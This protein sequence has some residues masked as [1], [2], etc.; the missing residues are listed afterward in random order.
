MPKHVYFDPW[1]GTK[2]NQMKYRADVVESQ[3]EQNAT[4]ARDILAAR[5]TRKQHK[6]KNLFARVFR[7]KT[8][9]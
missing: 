9:E 4:H 3:L 2:G 1:M 7:K 6:K 5:E 8:S